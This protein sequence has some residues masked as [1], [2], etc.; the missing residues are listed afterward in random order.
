MAL[1]FLW[2]QH[3][4]GQVSVSS[5]PRFPVLRAVRA[6]QLVDPDASLFFPLLHSTAFSSAS[7]LTPECLL[8][9]Y[10]G[11]F[12]SVLLVGLPQPL[13]L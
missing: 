9:N 6:W 3:S 7:L 5:C 10:S 13:A 8:K 2:L 12:S 4:V 11:R 1:A